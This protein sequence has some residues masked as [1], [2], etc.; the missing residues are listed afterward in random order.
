MFE[1]EYDENKTFYLIEVDARY[2]EE[3]DTDFLDRD[4]FIDDLSREIRYKDCFLRII[5]VSFSGLT[6]NCYQIISTNGKSESYTA[7]IDE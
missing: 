1:D 2:M 3:L 6:V 7:I 5:K 4:D